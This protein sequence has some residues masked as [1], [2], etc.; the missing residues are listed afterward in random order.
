M[1]STGQLSQQAPQLTQVSAS[2]TYCSS[3]SEMAS[4][5]QLS[6]Q[7]PHLTQA[8][9]ILY[10][11]IMFLPYV[12]LIPESVMA[13]NILAWIFEKAIPILHSPYIFF[14]TRGKFPAL[15]GFAWDFGRMRQ[16]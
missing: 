5:G 13:N 2:M 9:V 3:P 7:A 15:G 10:A 8:S 14:A 1:A 16:I 12:F 4:T 11:M 6:A